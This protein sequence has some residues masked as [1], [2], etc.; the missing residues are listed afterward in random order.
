MMGGI[1]GNAHCERQ[2]HSCWPGIVAKV[3]WVRRPSGAPH[4]GRPHDGHRKI[5]RVVA[6]DEDLCHAFGEEVRIWGARLL[7]VLLDL[8]ANHVLNHHICKR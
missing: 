4:Q 7:K 8:H 1:R 3:A 2:P 5:G 6:A